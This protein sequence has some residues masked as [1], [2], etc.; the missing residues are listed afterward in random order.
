MSDNVKYRLTIGGTNIILDNPMIL[1]GGDEDKIQQYVPR[2]LNKLSI[3]DGKN[4]V[5]SLELVHV[6]SSD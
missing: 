2:K 5:V 4:V 3:I 1:F 6:L